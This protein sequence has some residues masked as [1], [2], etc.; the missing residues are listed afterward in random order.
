MDSIATRL[1]KNWRYVLGVP[2]S[3]FI[4]FRTLPFSQAIK[5]PIL[6]SHRTRLE[7][8]SGKIIMDKVKFASVKIGFGTT[9][10]ADFRECMTVI[11]LRGTWYIQTKCK[12][13]SGTKIHVQGELHTGPGFNVTGSTSIICHKKIQFGEHVLISWGVHIM[14]TDQHPIYNEGRQHINANSEIVIGNHV[15]ICSKSTVLKGSRL[16][17]NSVLGAQSLLSKPIEE[18]NVLVAGMPAKVIKRG[19]TWK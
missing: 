6:V 3:L 17:D 4:N 16:S 13:G 1:I 2:K 5:L 15:W 19:I 10:Y 8:L 11:S 18:T 14:D 9:E 7:N 12:I